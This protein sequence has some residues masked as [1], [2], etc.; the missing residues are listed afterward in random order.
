MNVQ[1]FTA[2]GLWMEQY[3]ATWSR[4][5]LRRLLAR[6]CP[7]VTPVV[8]GKNLSAVVLTFWFPQYLGT[9]LLPSFLLIRHPFL[10][11][12]LFGHSNYI[13]L[14][15]LSCTFLLFPS[16]FKR[17]HSFSSHFSNM[18]LLL[19]PSSP[20]SLPLPSFC[21]SLL[22]IRPPFPF[23]NLNP[24]DFAPPSNFRSEFSTTCEALLRVRVFVSAIIWGGFLK[25]GKMALESPS[26]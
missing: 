3:I 15:G 26:H 2:E 23:P 17:F 13:S 9:F 22:P 12:P 7:K 24:S 1:G 14:S 25:A 5:R 8:K 20:F 19:P 11:F 6:L 16:S 4:R 18:S 21:P 10:I